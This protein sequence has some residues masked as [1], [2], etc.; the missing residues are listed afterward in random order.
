[1]ST[2]LNTE[3]RLMPCEQGRIDTEEH[4]NGAGAGGQDLL[5]CRNNLY[6]EC[7]TMQVGHTGLA[8]FPPASK[9]CDF[10]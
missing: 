10:R 5:R 9:L 1:M 8:S 7:P 3:R 4:V 2:S 6:G